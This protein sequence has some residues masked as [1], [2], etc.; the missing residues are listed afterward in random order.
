MNLLRRLCRNITGYRY[1]GVML[2]DGYRNYISSNVFT[3]K[4]DAEDYSREL[5]K[6]CI[7]LRPTCIVSFRTKH[8]IIHNA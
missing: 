6:E 1:Y 4:G 3:S 7:S 8:K 2:Y 5:G